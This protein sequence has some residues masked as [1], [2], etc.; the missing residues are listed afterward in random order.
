MQPEGYT[1][2]TS[3]THLSVIPPA[4]PHAAEDIARS[5][6]FHSYLEL[7]DAVRDLLAWMELCLRQGRH[8][9]H[10]GLMFDN[11]YH[12]YNWLQT[13]SLIPYGREEVFEDLDAIK[14]YLD[15]DDKAG[16]LKA[17]EELTERF[18]AGSSPPK[19]ES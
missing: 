17:L 3:F 5:G 12:L 10:Y 11:L 7:P 15:A 13:E 9:Q 8:E 1:A 4:Y 14:Q 2:F 18:R 19:I 16:A 6:A